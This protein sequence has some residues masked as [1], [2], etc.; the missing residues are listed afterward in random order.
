M[1]RPQTEE[2]RDYRGY[3]GTVASGTVSVL[4]EIIVEA[5]TIAPLPVYGLT[6]LQAARD[7]DATAATRSLDFM[8]SPPRELQ[9]LLVRECG[10]MVIGAT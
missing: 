8:H 7:S 5:G 3:T 2:Y 6:V 1:L 10:S 9:A 4:N